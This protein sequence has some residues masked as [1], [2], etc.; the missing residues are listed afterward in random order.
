MEHSLQL[1]ELAGRDRVLRF[2]PFCWRTRF[3]VAHKGLSLRTIPILFSEK[4][5]IAPYHSDRVPVLL[6]RGHVIPDS[7]RIAEYLEKTYPDRPSLFHGDV[8]RGSSC[9]IGHWTDTSLHPLILRSVISDI[10]DA[11]DDRDREYFR[12]S[13]EAR[14]G[15][16]LEQLFSEAGEAQAALS[17]I[18]APIRAT[19][20]QQEFL[21]GS[22]PAYPDF[23]VCAAFQWIRIVRKGELLAIG[24]P[25]LAWREKIVTRY[26]STANVHDA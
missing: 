9:F 5:K 18:L 12:K 22:E 19:L 25:I 23:I 13:R 10:Y 21:S 20:Q 11:L 15:C 8:G 26:M 24:D 6:D 7:W 3:A 2:S 14:F 16:P 1:Y 4:E 17:K